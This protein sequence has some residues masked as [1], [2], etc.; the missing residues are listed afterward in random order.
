MYFTPF[1]FA[2]SY[3]YFP[4]HVSFYISSNCSLLR[5]YLRLLCCTSFVCC[6][7][8]EYPPNIT[9]SV[10]RDASLF[11]GLFLSSEGSKPQKPSR[12]RP[13][14]SHDASKFLRETIVDFFIGFMI[15]QSVYRHSPHYWLTRSRR[16][17]SPLQIQICTCLHQFVL[18]NSWSN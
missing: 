8:R 12:R 16:K 7:R 2:A 5:S 10:S 6:L 1:L 15:E 4:K 14:H 9:R 3:L 13:R 18:R 11:I 17:I